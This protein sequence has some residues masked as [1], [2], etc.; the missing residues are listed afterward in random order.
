MLRAMLGRSGA[1]DAM[2]NGRGGD[3]MKIATMIVAL[4]FLMIGC[5]APEE[6]STSSAE[7]KTKH[8]PDLS[9]PPPPP[10]GDMAMQPSAIHHCEV[11]NGVLTG[12]CVNSSCTPVANRCGDCIRGTAATVMGHADCPGVTVSHDFCT[13]PPQLCP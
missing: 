5:G 6:E 11:A 4:G 12:N 10:P 13:A 2:G 9:Q 8:Q 1:A 3:E 7:L